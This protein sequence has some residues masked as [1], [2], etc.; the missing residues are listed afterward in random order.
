MARRAEPAFAPEA[1]LRAQLERLAVVSTRPHGH[2]HTG[3]RR[4]RKSGSSIE[5]ADYRSYTPRDDYRQIDWNVYARSDELFVKVRESEEALVVH[6][7]LDASASMATG[8]PPKFEIAQRLTA[9]LG[10][11]ALTSHDYLAAT[12]IGGELEQRFPPQQGRVAARRFFDFL[13]DRSPSGPTRLA[14]SARAHAA[15]G[16]P[17]G[18]AILISDLLT[19]D[20]TQA[21]GMLAERGHELVV[22][23]VLDAQGMHADV[24]EE[25][26]LVDVES[27]ASLELYGDASLLASFRATVAEWIDDMQAFCHRR[28][29]RYIPIESDWAVEE[30]LLRRLRAHRVLA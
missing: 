8:R 14:A 19:D 11:V 18:V 27:G 28:H 16:G 7:F 3:G 9:A 24:A 20:A 15:R 12:L 4:S 25:V 5:F 22:I 13:D 29:A 30:V 2:L 1:G 6:L 23:H 17:H 26:E 10:W 21:I